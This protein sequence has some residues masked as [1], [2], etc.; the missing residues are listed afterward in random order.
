[1][2]A[3]VASLALLYEHMSTTRTWRTGSTSLKSTLELAECIG[4]NMRGGEVI[5]LVS[6]LGGGKTAFVRGLA[7]GLGSR[8]TVRS[9]SFT[10]GNQYRANKLTLHHFDFYRLA[11]PGIM[12]DELA[13]VLA[14]SRAAVVVEWADIIEDVL[15]AERLT[16]RIKATSETGREF[17]FS[18]PD[19]LTYLIP[20]KRLNMLAIC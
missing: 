20:L 8:D 18:Y 16:V 19:R 5:E 12:R 1:M 7:A 17:T 11:E 10:L 6:D 15:P 9:P 14:D 2:L 4:R 3:L 13:E